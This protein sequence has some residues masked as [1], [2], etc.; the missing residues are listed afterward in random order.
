MCQSLPYPPHHI[1]NSSSTDL[2]DPKSVA[3]AVETLGGLADAVIIATDVIPAFDLGL[4]I[5]KKHGLFMVVGQPRD[6]IPIP[7]HQVNMIFIGLQN[8]LSRS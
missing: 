2:K 1:L 5:V 7:F 6:P 8:V 3:K 4:E